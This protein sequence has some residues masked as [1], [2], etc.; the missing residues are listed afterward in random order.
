MR[1]LLLPAE[2]LSPV[3]LRIPRR[4]LEPGDAPRPQHDHRLDPLQVL[5]LGQHEPQTASRC[6]TSG[7]TAG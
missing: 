4:V 6:S 5:L 7:T 2:H 1:A 3:A